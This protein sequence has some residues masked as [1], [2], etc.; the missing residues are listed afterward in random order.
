MKSFDVKT[1][2]FLRARPLMPLLLYAHVPG[3]MDLLGE[4]LFGK[5]NEEEESVGEVLHRSGGMESV[6][7]R[8]DGCGGEEGASERASER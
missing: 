4:G 1:S 5:S 6:C 7:Q 3:L 8:K 2:F